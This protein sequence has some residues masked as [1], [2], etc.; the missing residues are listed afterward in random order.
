MA[1]SKM[2]HCGLLSFVILA[3]LFVS[4]DGQQFEGSLLLLQTNVSSSNASV[5]LLSYSPSTG[6]FRKIAEYAGYRSGSFKGLDISGNRVFVELDD[7]AGQNPSI[8]KLLTLDVSKGTILQSASLPP[9]VVLASA[10]DPFQN[11]LVGLYFDGAD[12]SLSLS[13]VS[14]VTGRIG[15]VIF[16]YNDG[17]S[18]TFAVFDP[19]NYLL[20]GNPSDY[21]PAQ[22]STIQYST[23]ETLQTAQ[24][25]GN[26]QVPTYNSNTKLLLDNA[27]VA[28]ENSWGL[29]TADPATG[30][31]TS[32]GV[33]LVYGVT[34]MGQG[35]AAFDSVSQTYFAV[36]A[37][38]A[39]P[40]PSFL[41]QVDLPSGA[42]T[43]TVKV[44][45]VRDMMWAPS[46]ASDV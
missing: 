19:D 17:S 31:Y 11:A 43:R 3:L 42:V 30:D 38:G 32:T 13:T 36:L 2:V 29:Y 27:L 10:W 40:H 4:I 39:Y 33:T 12:N 14:P 21:N 18:F 28:D 8:R 16:Q 46:P 20:F 35:P 1:P 41:Y 6:T 22:I 26:L 24:L 23:G 25:A 5:A 15:D 7:Q 34:S 45:T 37:P 9:T 44:E